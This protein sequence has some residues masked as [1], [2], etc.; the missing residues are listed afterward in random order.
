[1]CCLIFGVLAHAFNLSTGG[2]AIGRQR[3]RGRRKRHLSEFEAILIYRGSS[4][5]TKATQKN[6]VSKK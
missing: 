2:R 4:R 1:L 5:T 6:P 3:Q